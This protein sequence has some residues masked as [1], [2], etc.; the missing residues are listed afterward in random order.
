[1]I[2]VEFG[3]LDEWLDLKDLLG[4]GHQFSLDVKEEQFDACLKWDAESQAIN[5]QLEGQ[6]FSA[7]DIAPCLPILFAVKAF[8]KVETDANKGEL[9]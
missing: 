8:K 2:N 9:M 1:M 7:L 3:Q 5:L 6:D 4:N